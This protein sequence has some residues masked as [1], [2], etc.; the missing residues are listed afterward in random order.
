VRRLALVCAVV[1]LAVTGCKG[2]GAASTDGES[3]SDRLAAAK[4]SFDN[5]VYTAFTL[6]TDHLP[7]GLQGLLSASGTGTHDPAFTG[8]VKVQTNVTDITAPL[9]ALDGQV[10]AKLPFV[11]WQ[12]LDPADYGAPDP[13]NLMDTSTGISS[14]F[15]AIQNPKVGDSSRD[16]SKVLTTISGTLSGDTV[17]HVFPSAGSDSFDVTYTL[18]SD[19]DIDGATITG[20]FYAGQDDVT[21]TIDFTL[22]ADAVDIQAPAT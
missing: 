11:G 10:Y 9:V 8:D 15:T 13:A 18:T 20:P 6:Q 14:L 3:P 21:Y 5:S 22:D 17:Q 4:K 19:D 7:D 12:T 1:V 2:S 16:G